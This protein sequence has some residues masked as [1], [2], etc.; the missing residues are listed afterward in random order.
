MKELWSLW[1]HMKM[2]KKQEPR[3]KREDREKL[4]IELKVLEEDIKYRVESYEE[5]IKY[6]TLLK[7]KRK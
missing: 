7:K 2:S 4:L 5:I 6:S 3:L 1:T